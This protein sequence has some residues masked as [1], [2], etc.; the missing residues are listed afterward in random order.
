MDKRG[1][2]VG[3]GP[4]ENYSKGEA[5]RFK[6]SKRVACFAARLSWVMGSAASEGD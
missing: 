2:R 1:A 4:L 6:E 5:M 3:I